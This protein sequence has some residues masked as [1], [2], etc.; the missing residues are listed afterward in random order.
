MTKDTPLFDAVYPIIYSIPKCLHMSEKCPRR[1]PLTSRKKLSILK[2]KF[3]QT[4]SCTA[5]SA[6]T[7]G[8]VVIGFVFAFALNVARISSVLFAFHAL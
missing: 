4:T 3:I 7:G 5:F 8:K 6:I 2:K 1:A